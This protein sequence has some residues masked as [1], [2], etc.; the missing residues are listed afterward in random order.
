MHSQS[1]EYGDD[2][3]SRDEFFRAVGWLSLAI[4]SGVGIAL[5]ARTWRRSNER[6]DEWEF[7]VGHEQAITVKAPLEVVEEAWIEWCASGHAKLGNE[8]AVRFEPAPGARGTEVHI[9][10]GGSTT[11]IRDE[12]RRFKQRLETG[13]ILRSDGPGLFRP[14][15]PRHSAQADTLTEVH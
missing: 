1:Q 2:R 3:T 8:Y 14:A 10:G 5:A 12:L 11:T 13:E 15:Q 6:F 9:S 4:A 7:D